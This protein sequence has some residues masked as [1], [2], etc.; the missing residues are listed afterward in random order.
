MILR[1]CDPAQMT[2]DVA[3]QVQ[4]YPAVK[5]P[6]VKGQSIMVHSYSTILQHR[7]LFLW[8]LPVLCLCL[9]LSLGGCIHAEGENAGSLTEM[10]QIQRGSTYE[11][12]ERDQQAPVSGLT[13]QNPLG[14]PTLLYS[15]YL[16]GD[17]VDYGKDVAVDAA[18][19]IYVIGQTYSDTLFDE[20]I[21]RKGYSDIFVAKLNPAG[22]KLL[23]SVVIGGQ[24]SE[25]PLSIAVD[26]QGNVYG[27]ATG[28]DDTFPTTENALWP[29]PLE[30]TDMVLFKLDGNGN[31]V[32]STYLPLEGFYSRH[33]LAVDAEGNVYVAAT[34]PWVVVD[35]DTYMR[36][37]LGLVK[38]DP[39]G[40]QVLLDI[41]IGGNGTDR[42]SAIALDDDGN[43]YLTG[44]TSEGDGFPVTE[45][46]HQKE[47]GDLIADPDS[48]CYEDGVI[49]VLNPA[50]EV[51]YSSYHG[52]NFTEDPQAI[53]TDGKG[54]IVIA[55]DTASSDF[56]LV[57]AIQ[58]SC[59]LA[60]E[61]DSCESGH[62][63]VSVIHLD[64][65]VAT[66]TFSSYL[67]AT[68]RNS[69]NVVFAAVMDSAGNAYV[70]GYTSGKKFPLMNP[71]QDE[72]YESFCY[73]FSSERYC[74]DAFIT[75]FSPKG[76]LLMGTYL[77]AAYDEFPYGLKLDKKGNLY[78]TGTTEADDFPTTD[79]AYE[80]SNLLEDD[81]FL[82]KIG[83]SIKTAPPPPAPGK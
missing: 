78:V 35:E 58:E 31:V 28:S 27:T 7:S 20:E 82:V 24:D 71:I 74:F 75:K 25:Y 5:R 57:N 53:D 67:G 68:E 42:A 13:A 48:Y 26:A 33:T 51:T 22:D 43:I 11:N 14:G 70:S 17:G 21:E 65:D 76:D 69:D 62:G 8:I 60:S 81:A 80:S 18:G 61:Y 64:D 15:T 40:T 10:M 39:T 55:G 54:N 63:F 73:T 66:L 38:L 1:P 23:Y 3:L 6:G 72:L 2:C 47:C 19:N 37:Q 77:G 41:N 46:A 49:V 36:D 34:Y 16:G 83:T 44:T 79:N 9:I 45:N 50:G 52:G 30:Y 59:Y 4:L 29:A 32:Y 12:M 56:P